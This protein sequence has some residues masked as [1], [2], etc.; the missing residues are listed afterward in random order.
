[1]AGAKQPIELLIAKG[2]KHLTK[3]EIESRRATEVQP[4]TDGIAPPAYLT[5]AQKRTFKKLAEQLVKIRIM[6][7]TDVDALARYV[8]AQSLYEDVTKRLRE[9][10]A[11]S[12]D[13]F[14]IDQL[15][16]LQD[17]YCKQ[18]HTLAG[19]LGLTITSRCKLEVPE[20]PKRETPNKFERFEKKVNA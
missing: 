12:D 6:G 18:A 16:K 4:C 15:S 5:P 10:M 13:I 19:A 9:A 14:E 8:T 2:N 7:E 17:R 20:P 3:E 1:M 11:D